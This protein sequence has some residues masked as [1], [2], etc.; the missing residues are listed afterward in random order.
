MSDYPFSQL[1]FE[2]IYIPLCL[3]FNYELGYPVQR[4]EYI[5][6]PL[7]LYFNNV[8]ELARRQYIRFTFHYVSILI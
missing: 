3:Y 8:P 6:I 2:H 5:Y 1:S 7:C 4:R